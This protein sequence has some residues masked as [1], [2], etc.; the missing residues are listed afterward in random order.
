MSKHKSKFPIFKQT[1]LLQGPPV[2]EIL[3]VFCSSPAHMPGAIHEG[4][5]KNDTG[6]V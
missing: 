1:Y 4:N 3:G 6:K 5:I 2:Q